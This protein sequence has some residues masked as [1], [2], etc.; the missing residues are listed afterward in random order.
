VTRAALT[1][2]VIGRLV[3][4]MTRGAIRE[5]RVIKVGRQPCAR[6]VTGAALTRVVIGGLVF[7]MACGT[8]GQSG[9]IETRR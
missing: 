9:M 3:F 8:V 4:G 5:A 7:G 1:R 6:R 2:V